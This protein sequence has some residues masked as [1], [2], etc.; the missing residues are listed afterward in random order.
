MSHDVVALYSPH[1]VLC[2]ASLVYNLH[3]AYSLLQWSK[4]QS[5]RLNRE[6]AFALSSINSYVGCK[7]WLKLK[8]GIRSR[9]N[10]LVCHNIV[11]SGCLLANLLNGALKSVVR[12]GVNGECYTFAFFN[13]TYISLV[14]ICHN[15]HVGKVLCDSKQLWSRE[16]GCN[17]LAFFYRFRQYYTV[18]R[19]CDSGITKVG[20]CALHLFLSRNHLLLSLCIR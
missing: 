1:L 3:L 6:H 8:V 15:L 18:N 19:R 16:A 2:I 11:G 14:N 10:H 12:I 4:S 13:I 7:T 17:S 20:L 5:L 9:Y